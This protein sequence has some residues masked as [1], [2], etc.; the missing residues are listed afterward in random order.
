[1]KELCSDSRM[2]WRLR[3]FCV[4]KIDEN[5]NFSSLADEQLLRYSNKF[6]EIEQYTD[7]DVN[8]AYWYELTCFIK[9]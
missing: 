9:D 6:K 4:A 5:G 3:R 8:K 7:E 2:G 1:M